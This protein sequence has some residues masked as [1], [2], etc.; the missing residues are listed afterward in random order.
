MRSSQL[1][2]RALLC[3]YAAS[4][5]SFL[6]FGVAYVLATKLGCNP[7]FG[8][9]ACLIAGIITALF[10]WS[11]L[12]PRLAKMFPAVADLVANT[13]VVV[14]ASFKRGVTSRPNTVNVDE[15]GR[16]FMQSGSARPARRVAA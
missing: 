11:W 7:R 8:L 14:A 1:S 10:M 13:A 16:V 5:A 12:E 2:Q 3:L 15:S 4:A 6:P 9:A